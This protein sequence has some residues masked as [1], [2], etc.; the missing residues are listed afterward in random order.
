MDDVSET[1]VFGFCHT[2]T[3]I[4]DEMYTNQSDTADESLMAA[5][6]EVRDSADKGSR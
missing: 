3:A 6:H 5:L 2:V 1:V 4:T